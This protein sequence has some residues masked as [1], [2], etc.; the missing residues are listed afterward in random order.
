M[1]F[2]SV[3]RVLQKTKIS[4]RQP[5]CQPLLYTSLNSQLRENVSSFNF[6]AI[7][8]WSHLLPD[9]H[10]IFRLQITVTQLN[11]MVRRQKSKSQNGGYEK[12]KH[13]RVFIKRY[14]MLF[15]LENMVLLCFIV[16]T[17]LRFA[18]LA[19][20]P[21]NCSNHFNV[22]LVSLISLC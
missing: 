14:E 10:L 20:L 11:S 9:F 17:V 12:I 7:T 18:L 1:A 3:L 16:T 13:V 22:R 19:L 5:W 21:T 2:S 15:F 8:P 4:C 6:L